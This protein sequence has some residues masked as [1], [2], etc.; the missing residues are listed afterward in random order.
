MDRY[1]EC[2]IKQFEYCKMPDK[3]TF[4]PSPVEKCFANHM[5][6]LIA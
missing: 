6:N 5:K 2:V 1:L 4:E 3:E